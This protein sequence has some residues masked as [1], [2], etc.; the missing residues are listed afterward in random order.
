VIDEIVRAKPSAAKGKYIRSATLT[1]TMGPGIK[2]DSGK[3]GDSGAAPAKAASEPGDTP[4]DETPAD[5]DETPADTGGEAEESAENT[6]E[7]A[8]A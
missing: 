3:A 7:A 8:T 4:P 1:T 2:V 5:P 6:E